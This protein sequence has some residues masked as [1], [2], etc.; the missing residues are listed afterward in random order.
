MLDEA[1]DRQPLAERELRGAR[2]GREAEVVAEA[3]EL[4][5]RDEATEPVR[6]LRRSGT[7]VAQRVLGEDQEPLSL[8]AG[9]PLPLMTGAR[10]L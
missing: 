7:A 1:E 9:E 5:A 4:A 10:G 3:G 8:M 2:V 6:H